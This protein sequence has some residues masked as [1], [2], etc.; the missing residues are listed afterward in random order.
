MNTTHI[1]LVRKMENTIM[2]V[3]YILSKF[4]RNIGDVMTIDNMAFKVICTGAN[5]G[6][7]IDTLND[8]IRASNK[9]AK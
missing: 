3:R 4:E 2:E 7:V 9:R 5:R 8:I 6:E 1:G